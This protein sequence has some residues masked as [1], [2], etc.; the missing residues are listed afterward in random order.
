MARIQIDYE[1]TFLLL[2]TLV[3]KFKESSVKEE[4]ILSI[5][6][7]EIM[8]GDRIG[9]NRVSITNINYKEIDRTEAR[10]LA[11]RLMDI[12]E[13]LPYSLRTVTALWIKEFASIEVDEDE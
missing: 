9:L 5:M 10:K 7:E 6:K 12:E 3:N 13:D 11:G 2:N 8:V 4:F 1:N